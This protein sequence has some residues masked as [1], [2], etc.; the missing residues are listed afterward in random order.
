MAIRKSSG[1]EIYEAT[2]ENYGKD[3]A[4]KSAV[5]DGDCGGS[6]ALCGAPFGILLPCFAG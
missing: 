1:K 2:E 5:D 4:E 6:L 3:A